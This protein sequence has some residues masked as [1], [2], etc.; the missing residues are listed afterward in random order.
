MMPKNQFNIKYISN[1]NK[2]KYFKCKINCFF[3]KRDDDNIAKV[4][5]QDIIRIHSPEM[6]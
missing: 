2:V 4:L 5:N 3:S 6:F 1:F